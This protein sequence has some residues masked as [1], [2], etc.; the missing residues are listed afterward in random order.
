MNPLN[1]F[2]HLFNIFMPAGCP[3]CG[4]STPVPGICSD[5]KRNIIYIEPPYCSI[6]GKPFV[7]GKGISHICID[8]IKGKSRFV[9]SRAVFEYN[10][11]IAELIQRFKFNDRVNL[12]SLFVNELLNLYKADFFDEGINA[13]IPVPLSDK[14]LK[15]RSYNQARL[16]AKGLS[17]ELSIP[18]YT[19]VIKKVKEIPPQSTLKADA[20]YNNV[21]HAYT[22]SGG[23]LL[24]ERKVL[25]VDDVITTGAT[26][27]ACIA[28]LHRAG[29]KQVY[30]M[31]IAMRV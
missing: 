9:K 28:A 20:R 16:L 31:A 12:S 19:D 29:I 18:C 17:R 5:C 11:L 3:I 23:D 13:I 4:R 6:C 26:V 10:G 22:V 1:G 24:K 7:S 8:C 14:R 27:N 15:Q 30:T 25:L 21:K 2:E